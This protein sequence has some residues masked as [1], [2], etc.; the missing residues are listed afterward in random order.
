MAIKRVPTGEPSIITLPTLVGGIQIDVKKHVST[1]HWDAPHVALWVAGVPTVFIWERDA[2]EPVRVDVLGTDP[3]DFDLL[4]EDVRAAAAFWDA[5][6]PGVID[7][8]R[9]YVRTVIEHESA[10]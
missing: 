8:W 5:E 7:R 6:L 3:S 2:A 10:A 9:H 1:E 4:P